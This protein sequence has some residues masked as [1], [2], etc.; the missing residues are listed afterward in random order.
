M[1]IASPSY[2]LWMTISLMDTALCGCILMGMLYVV[3]YAPRGEY[4][5]SF[6]I[7]GSIP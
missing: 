2:L 5:A 1:I 7:L 6:W 4:T 3:V